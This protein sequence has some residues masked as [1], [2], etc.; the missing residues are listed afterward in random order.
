M[1]A[2]G[3][4]IAAGFGI[5]CDVRLSADGIAFVHHDANLTRMAGRNEALASLPA[6]TLDGLSLPDGGTIPRLSALLNR[7]GGIVPLLIEVKLNH[8]P[9]ASL[10]EAIARDLAP[11][12]DAPLAVM[13]FNPRVPAW[14]ARHHP[15]VPRGLV[16]TQ[17]G[18]PPLRSA[19]ERA[20]AYRLA[21]P[22]FIACDI[23]DL[24]SPFSI[25]ARKKGLPVLTWTVR[26]DAD[27]QRAATHA[28]QVIF[29]RAHD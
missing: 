25:R 11:L 20:L 8:G 9:A 6:A 10:C 17:Q 2:F 1:A 5:E 18:K 12:P 28:D 13:S 23:R 24:P 3:A 19:V 16:V 21:R 26:S 22:D 4:A 14:F 27:R 15:H 7:S 29:E